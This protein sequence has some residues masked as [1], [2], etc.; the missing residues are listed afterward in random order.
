[1]VPTTDREGPRAGLPR[2]GHELIEQ[3]ADAPQSGGSG[4]PFQPRDVVGIERHRDRLLGHTYIYT[5]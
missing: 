1:M 3:L 2:G 5:I 4:P